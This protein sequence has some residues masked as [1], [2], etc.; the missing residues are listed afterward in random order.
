M[1]VPFKELLVGSCF[2]GKKGEI[3]KK[4][5][6]NKASIVNEESRKVKTRKIKETAEVEPA[7][8]PLG[9]LGVGLRRHPDVVV[10]IGDGNP[11]RKK[12]KKS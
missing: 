5:S 6:D 7:I 9:L 10:E 12:G 8:C 3:T 4:V 1:K 2:I 11:F